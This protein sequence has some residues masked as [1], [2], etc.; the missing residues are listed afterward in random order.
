MKKYNNFLLERN[1]T[2]IISEEETIKI[3]LTCK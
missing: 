3:L 1:D 2:K